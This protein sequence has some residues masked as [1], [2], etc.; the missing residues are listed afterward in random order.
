MDMELDDI[1]ETPSIV[2][3]KARVKPAPKPKPKP[4][5]KS[6]AAKKS[7]PAKKKAG[8][9]A[10]FAVCFLLMAILLG[11]AG[12]AFWFNISDVKTM[13]VTTLKLDQEEFTYLE[14]RKNELAIIEAD[15]L[16]REKQLKSDRQDVDKMQ[17]TQTETEAELTT[18]ASDLDTLEA[19]LTEQKTNLDSIVAIYEAMEPANAAA[20]LMAADTLQ[21]N[22]SIIKNMNQSKL[23]LI[24]AEMTP[25]QAAKV[26][27]LLAGDQS[28][29][30]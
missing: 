28:S 5:A 15:L 20:I 23:A 1:E 12:G 16:D 8:F 26:L 3:S 24:L 21:E 10:G 30:T 6:A 4:A 14:N 2:P 27:A 25:A 18:R 13:V 29:S 22:L 17:Q 7:S 11:A 19:S 9:G